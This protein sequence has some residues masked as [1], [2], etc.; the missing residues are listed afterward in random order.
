MD[1]SEA[2]K[3]LFDRLAELGWPLASKTRAGLTREHVTNTIAA[4][5]LDCPEGVIEFYA[6]ADGLDEPPGALI[7]EIAVFPGYYWLSLEEAA[8]A[9]ASLSP[10]EDWHRTWF[11]IFASGGGDFYA[12]ICDRASA[13]FGQVVGFLRGETDQI[14]EFA[15]LTTMLRTMA[16]AYARG[17]FT[18]EGREVAGDFA[19]MRPIA[20]LAQPDFAEHDA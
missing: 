19:L 3:A 14:V 12:V 7:G 16:E 6:W 17:A 9:Y 13:D 10:S 1:T 15:S 5:G 11:P 18:I 8:T 4:L 2:A 20:Q